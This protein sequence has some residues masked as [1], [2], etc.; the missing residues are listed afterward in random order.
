[1]GKPPRSSMRPPSHR[2]YILHARPV[3]EPSA[4]RPI[5]SDSTSRRGR[6]GLPLVS[7]LR[8]FQR[9]RANEEQRSRRNAHEQENKQ[10]NLG[11]VLR[12]R[13]NRVDQREKRH[14]HQELKT[15]YRPKRQPFS[16]KETLPPKYLNDSNNDKL[17]HHVK[18]PAKQ[19]VMH[20]GV[21]P[22]MFGLVAFSNLA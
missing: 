5:T 1:M 10:S 4:P 20:G 17:D 2:S 15:H 22:F 3:S 18:H 12:I 16:R 8:R 11:T 9:Q 7:L 13:S 21:P 14:Q 19:M 6:S